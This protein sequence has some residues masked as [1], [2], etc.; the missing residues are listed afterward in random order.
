MTRPIGMSG[1]AGTAAGATSVT[2]TERL[3]AAIQAQRDEIQR[4]RSIH[5]TEMDRMQARLEALIAA[6]QALTPAI[7]A[8][9][10]QLAAVGIEV[11]A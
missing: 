3:T 10:G 11:T 8:I 5:Q 9:I 1:Q 2:L 7:E 4:T 6:R